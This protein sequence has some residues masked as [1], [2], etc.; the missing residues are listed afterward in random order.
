MRSGLEGEA[1]LFVYGNLLHCDGVEHAWF[2]LR[3]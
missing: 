3:I 1:I 2:V